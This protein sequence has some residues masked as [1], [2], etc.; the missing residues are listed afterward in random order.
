MQPNIGLAVLAGCGAQSLVTLTGAQGLGLGFG[1]GLW[2]VGRA[3]A[4]K[5]DRRPGG[6]GAHS[7]SPGE[8]VRSLGQAGAVAA[9]AVALV[10]ARLE[11]LDKSVLGDTMAR[12][13][14]AVL[15]SVPPG[16]VLLAHTDLDWNPVRYARLCEGR[17]PDVTHLSLQMMP[18]PWFPARQSPLYPDISFPAPFPGVDTNRASEGNA[19]V[20]Y[21]ID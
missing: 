9:L 15:S 17:R 13:A 1:L 20:L 3:N 18:F 14:E 4:G 5:G 16:G 10:V 6:N 7:T 19:Q 11:Q 8:A 12:Y 21:C 2:P